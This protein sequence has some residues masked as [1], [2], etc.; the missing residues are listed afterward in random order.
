MIFSAW[1]CCCILCQSCTFHFLHFLEEF[2]INSFRIVY[3]ACRVRAGDNL[4]RLL[5]RI[6]C[7]IA[8]AGY[9][10]CLAFHRLAVA[11]HQF[12]CEIEQTIA[13]SLCTCE[14][15]AVCKPLACENALKCTSDSLVLSKH[16]ADL[17]CACSDIASRNIHICADIFRKL[18]HETLAECH[19]LSV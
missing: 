13:C 10:N 11:L 15:T 4:L 2:H 19:N 16:K 3:P 7:N 12:L 8:S 6:D 18:C 17:S 9:D 5:C 14:G 1:P